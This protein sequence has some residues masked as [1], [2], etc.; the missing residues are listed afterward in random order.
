MMGKRSD[1]KRIARDLYDTPAAAVEPLLPWLKPKTC[2]IEPCLGNGCLAEHLKRA[3]H[4]LVGA[5]DLPD[6]ARLK[7]YNVEAGTMFISNPPAWGRPKD[8]HP[9]IENLADQAPCWLL[10]SADWLFNKTSGPLTRRLHRIVAVGRVKWIPNSP[11]V[12]KDNCAWL[13]FERPSRGP[14]FFIGRT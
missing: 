10:M 3:G 4:I 12:G 2:F 14:R 5:Y 11:H 9:M 6:D 1:F 7:Q 8:L 13:L